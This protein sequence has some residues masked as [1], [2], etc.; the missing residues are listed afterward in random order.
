MNFN[1]CLFIGGEQKVD[2][3]DVPECY[4]EFLPENL[5][6]DKYTYPYSYSPFLI[7]FNKEAE[8]PAKG[9]CYTDRFCQ[10]DFAR[11]DE[12][13]LKHFGNKGQHWHDR[14]PEKVQA[15]LCDWISREVVHV[16][17]I[18]YVNIGNGYPVWR[19]DFHDKE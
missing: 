9:T 3:S 14:D 11:H 17:N 13:C 10:Q 7:Y 5:E 6:K 1:N 4:H 19:L 12:L 2:R 16:A 18:Q 8:K 15:F